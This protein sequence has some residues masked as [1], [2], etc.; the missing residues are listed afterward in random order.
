MADE[1][2]R[3]AELSYEI[4]LQREIFSSLYKTLLNH[5]TCKYLAGQGYDG[6]AAMRDYIRSIRDPE[7]P[8]TLEDLHVVYEDGVMTTSNNSVDPGGQWNTLESVL[9]KSILWL[10]QRRATPGSNR[11]PFIEVHSD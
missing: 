10:E 3:D 5:H 9:T 4:E 2:S 11:D 7:K 8:A 6:L 1:E